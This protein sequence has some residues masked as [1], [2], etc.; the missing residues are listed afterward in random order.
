MTVRMKNTE[1]GAVYA[2][3]DSAVPF[4]VQ[5]GWQ[6]LGDEESAELDEQALQDAADAEQAMQDIAATAVAAGPPPEQAAA[7]EQA[8][9]TSAEQTSPPPAGDTDESDAGRQDNTTKET[10]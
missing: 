2:A 6:E 8:M 10:G 1:T 5:S 9:R 3:P 4:L 7:A